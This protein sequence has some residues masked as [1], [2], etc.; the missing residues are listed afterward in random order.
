MTRTEDVTLDEAPR[1]S[2]V[3]SSRAKLC[4]S[5]HFNAGGAEFLRDK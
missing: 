3:K 2:K 1:T 5:H 4:V